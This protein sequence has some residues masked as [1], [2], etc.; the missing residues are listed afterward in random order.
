MKKMFLSH[1][2]LAV[3]RRFEVGDSQGVFRALIGLNVH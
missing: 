2:L 3:E 1:P